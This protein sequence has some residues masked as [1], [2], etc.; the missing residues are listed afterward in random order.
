M[1]AERIA[2]EYDG[3]LGVPWRDGL[4]VLLDGPS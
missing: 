2:I 1:T 3:T 4:G